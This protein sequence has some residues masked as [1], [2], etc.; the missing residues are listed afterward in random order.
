MTAPMPRGTAR[1]TSVN[2]I[3]HLTQTRPLEMQAIFDF[4]YGGENEE[5][6]GKK[7]QK[8]PHESWE[9]DLQS[10][11]CVHRLESY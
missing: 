4:N 10:T 2:T 6:K 3:E 7:R 8:T 1:D 11:R 9:N 5:K